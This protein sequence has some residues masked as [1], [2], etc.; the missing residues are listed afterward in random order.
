MKQRNFYWLFA[1]VAFFGNVVGSN[2]LPM[3]NEYNEIVEKV[4]DSAVDSN[5]DSS[6]E[7]AA[8][9]LYSSLDLNS[10]IAP[11]RDVFAK[12]LKGYYQLAETGKVKNEKLTIVDFS[13][14]SAKPRL[15]V[16]DMK[17]N[18]ILLQSLVAHGK[19][20]GEEYATT[21]SNRINSHMSSLGFYTTGE[22]YTGR[23]GF[24][25]RLDGLEAG[26][27]DKA[28]ERAIVIHGADY[29]SPNLV[30]SQGKLGRSYGCPAV[31]FEVNDELIDMIKDKSLLFIYYP[32][33]QYLNSSKIV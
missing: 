17:E 11:S 2:T 18:T 14:S 24:S 16:I 3:S 20:T 12:A 9:S 8:S 19:K 23:N 10:F 29:A 13:L 25:L 28:R 15:W 4:A 21:F 27:N 6:F 1:S 33:N 32:S 26:I 7:S 22:T 31:P 30:R 5:E